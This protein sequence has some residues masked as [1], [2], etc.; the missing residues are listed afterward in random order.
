MM[1]LRKLT[2]VLASLVTLASAGNTWAG[3]QNVFQVT[4]NGCSNSGAAAV[5]AVSGFAPSTSY[6]GGGFTPSTSF[7]GSGS[8]G[9]D[10]GCCDPCP[11]PQQC[12]TTRYIQRSCYTPVVTM[13]AQTFTE[14]VTTM[15]TSFFWEP[16]TTVRY[17]CQ[18]DPCTCSYRQVACPQTCYRLR[19]Q[20]CPVTNLVQRCCM[21]PVT[22]YQKSCWW[23]P[24]TCC[25]LVDPCANRGTSV[26]PA[27]NDGGSSGAVPAVQDSGQPAVPANPAG[28]MGD[29]NGGGASLRKSLRPVTPPVPQPQQYVQPPAPRTPVVPKYNSIAFEDGAVGQPTLSGQVVQDS[30]NRPRPGAKLLF[31]SDAAAGKQETTTAD[32]AGKFKVTLTAGQWLVYVRDESGKAVYQT[33]VQVKQNENQQMMLVSRKQ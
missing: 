28:P 6:F 31:V 1:P 21:V 20:C 14:S 12:C 30:Q 23:E 7:S 25:S 18:F 33:K 4:C 24:Q 2:F 17:S 3:W 13:R 29:M 15:R 32:T 9:G 11:C 19:S 26:A 22:T 10:C 8:C 27:V 16:V 5:P